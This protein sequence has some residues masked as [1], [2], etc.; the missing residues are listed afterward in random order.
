M[1]RRIPASLTTDWNHPQHDLP[2]TIF[3]LLRAISIMRPI[4]DIRRTT[5]TRLF[6]T[7]LAAVSATFCSGALVFANPS[8]LP[9]HEG[10]PIGMAT[11]PV[12]GQSLGND[13]GRTN[14]TGQKALQQSAAA[15]D[16]HIRQELQ[17]NQNDERILEKP[18]AGLLPK[19]QGPQIAIEPPVKE[20]M[21]IQA[22][23]Q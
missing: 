15:D 5:M 22:A 16:A 21:K 17:M 10:Y 12:T 7:C 13:P 19:V 20:G 18:G 11:D 3:N 2:L 23:P 14:S 4:H 1:Y 9:K 8:M 6:T